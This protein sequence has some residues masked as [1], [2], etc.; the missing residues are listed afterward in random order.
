MRADIAYSDICLTPGL[1]SGTQVIKSP[2]VVVN[3]KV[4]DWRR[5]LL[6]TLFLPMPQ[7]PPLS[8]F[9]RS[10]FIEPLL[11]LKHSSG[12]WGYEEGW[13]TDPAHMRLRSWMEIDRRFW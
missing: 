12:H 10:L 8:F 4:A 6:L 11:L 1:L 9:P 13:G 7:S 3:Y 5:L 2:F